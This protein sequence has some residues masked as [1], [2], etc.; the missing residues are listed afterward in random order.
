[1]GRRARTQIWGGAMNENPTVGKQRSSF[2]HEEGSVIGMPPTSRHLLAL[3]VVAVASLIAV[4]VGVAGYIEKWLWMRQLGYAGIFWTL[5]SVQVVMFCS[6]FVFAFLY[7]WINLRQ[8]TKNSGDFLGGVRA[9]RPALSSVNVSA[10]PSIDLSPRLLKA[11]VFLISAVVAVFSAL[12]FYTE[13]D[14]Y[15]RF[16]YG[17]SFGVSDPLL[18][19]DVGFYLFHLPFYVLLQGSLTILTILTFGIVFST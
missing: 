18:G 14:T 5:L 11:A 17:G 19:V 12:Y 7:L 1:M 15:L 8:A 16:R 10:H 6:A 13:W 4:L 9:S 2:A 3:T